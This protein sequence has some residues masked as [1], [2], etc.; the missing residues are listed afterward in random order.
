MTYVN[1]DDKINSVEICYFSEFM[2]LN[3][4]KGE[5][6]MGI[7]S[8]EIIMSAT[9]P[10]TIFSLKPD[11]LDQEFEE[12][13]EAYKPQAYSNIQNF[14][15]MQKVTM[16]YRKAK[17]LLERGEYSSPYLGDGTLEFY[18][19][20][21]NHYSFRYIYRTNLKVSEMFVTDKSIIFVTPGKNRI[22]YENYV[23]KAK[24]FQRLDPNTWKL[25]EHMLP[26]IISKHET[27]DGDFVIYLKKPCEKIYPLREILN[28][29]DGKLR[30][31]YVASILNRL[32]SLLA[33]FEIVGINYNAFTIDTLFFA[34]GRITEEGKN[35]T[36]EDMRFI[37]AYG[38]WFFTTWSDEKVRGLPRE[39]YNLLSDEEKAHG[40][41]SFRA[42]ALAIKQVARELLGDVSGSDLGNTP[43]AM[44]E[45][46]NS[47]SC[48]RNAYEEFAAWEH[49]L[50]ASFGKRR[51]VDMDVS[52]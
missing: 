18:D 46:L 51:F 10:R 50:K 15:I 45:W 13:R 44:K 30:P 41:S 37:G 26:R 31:E 8:E 47:T 20:S 11:T 43:I 27:R 28:Y 39:M 16:L 12:Y 24:R 7:K 34:P 22:Y 14:I 32:Y 19:R 25:V 23:Q 6:Q 42:N 2:F 29:F 36:V 4:G 49:V 17:E 40:Y 5:N 35:Y 33:Y 3:F 38:G 21:D 9:S 52:I 1:F 48:E